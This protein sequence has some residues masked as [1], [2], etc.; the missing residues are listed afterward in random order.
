MCKK[1]MLQHDQK[2]P[3]LLELH[4]LKKRKK[5]K[6]KE[7]QQPE[8]RTEHFFV[9]FEQLKFEI[10]ANQDSFESE[11]LRFLLFLLVCL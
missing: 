7:E 11:L 4:L 8:V 3:L 5:K 2:R 6:N 1:T 9:L 10:L